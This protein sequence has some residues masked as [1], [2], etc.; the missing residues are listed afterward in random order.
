MATCSCFSSSSCFSNFRAVS[1]YRSSTGVAETCIAWPPAACNDA[2]ECQL[3][4]QEQCHGFSKADMGSVLLGRTGLSRPPTS[5]ILVAAQ[6][7]ARVDACKHHLTTHV[8]TRQSITVQ[9]ALYVC[10]KLHWAQLQEKWQ[11]VAQ[12][13]SGS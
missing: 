9:N 3:G 8:G 4:H 6:R 11:S 10:A 13:D 1:P 7:L 12:I 5:C 2:L